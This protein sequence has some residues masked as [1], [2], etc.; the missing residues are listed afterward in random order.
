MDV[1]LAEEAP[2]VEPSVCNKVDDQGKEE[3]TQW[4]QCTQCHVFTHCICVGME[5]TSNSYDSSRYK[6]MKCIRAYAYEK[7]Q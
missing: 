5:G 1:D 2:L 7:D 4:I 3:K 6:C